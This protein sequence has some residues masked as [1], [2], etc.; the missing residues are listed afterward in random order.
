MALSAPPTQSTE[1]KVAMVDRGQAGQNVESVVD[2]VRNAQVRTDGRATRR[3]ERAT[4]GTGSG[5]G[6]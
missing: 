6:G 3:E 1:E 5:G 2:E 4:R